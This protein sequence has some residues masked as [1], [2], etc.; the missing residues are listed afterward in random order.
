M[1]EG[2][3]ATM[4]LVAADAKAQDKEAL[5]GFFCHLPYCCGDVASSIASIVGSVFSASNFY[6]WSGKNPICVFMVS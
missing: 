3:T 6:L 2:K 1:L 5:A 4:I